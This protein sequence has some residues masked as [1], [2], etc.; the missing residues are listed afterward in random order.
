M[1][2]KTFDVEGMTCASC[3]RAVEKSVKK[4]KGVKDVSVNLLANK[5]EVTFDDSSSN[6]SEIK[7]SVAKAGYKA[8]ESGKDNS[9]RSEETKV[10]KIKFLVSLVFVVPLLYIAMGHMFGLPLPTFINPHDNLFNFAL[11]QLLLS[12]PVIVIGYK[13]YTVGFKSLFLLSPNMDSLVAL[14]TSTAFGYGVYTTMQI[15][16]GNIHEANLYFESAAVIITMIMLGKYFE[17][18]SKGRT[19]DAIRKL[20]DMS[21]KMATLLVDGQEQVVTVE[22]V[23]VGDYLIVKPGERLPVD[24]VI[25]Q[26][27]TSVDES[28][29]TG[30]PLP[31]D[32]QVGEKV[33]GASING[34]GSIIYQAT[35]V[36]NDTVLAQI[37]RLVESAQNSK[38]PIAKLA[39]KISGIFV[40]IVLGLAIVALGFW[41]LM[42]E[43]IEF[44][45]STMIAVLVIACP[46]AL[47]LA[48]PTAI[49]VGTG[50]GAEHG[51][52]I[53]SGEAFQKVQ[54]T[55][56]VV[57][58]KTGTI[59]SGKPE[60][61]D[62][63]AFEGDG[64]TLLSLVA[65]VEARS[66]HPLAK[67]IV[68]KAK[69]SGFALSAVD[70]FVSL[71][72][73]GVV[74][75]A[76]GHE[77][78]IGNRAM[79]IDQ[80]I[81]ISDYSSVI[82]KLAEEGKT[83][84]Y[85]AIDAR[86]A[87]IIAVSDTIKS[88]AKS[89]ISALHKQNIKV[90]M[91]TGDNQRTANEVARKTGIDQVI[92]DVLPQ[93]KAIEIRKLRDNGQVVV[94]VGDGIN[95]AIALA[96]ADVGIAIGSGT[97]IAIESASIVLMRGD[98]RD[99]LTAIDLSKKTMKNV[100]ENLFWAFF[101]N[102]LGI[103]VAMGLL[104]LFGGPLLDPMIAGA[105]MSFSSVS[106]VLNAL[107]LKRFKPRK[108]IL[109]HD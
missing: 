42:G 12:V 5:M 109:T 77:V 70:N 53:K 45:I 76:N 55:T 20:I 7:K 81:V 44:A 94:M 39:D 62:M 49:M 47:G 17:A 69:S 74:G 102:L 11:V 100:K 89:V 25:T 68:D 21:P 32:K 56:I 93:D 43:N 18:L 67:A 64:D 14:G 50:K 23:M 4:V 41:L 60:V 6:I 16:L 35:K 19:S 26:G 8:K 61:S 59:T 52:L 1:D 29:L 90:Y 91:L 36:G 2:K 63:I 79:M 104:H 97:D 48:T 66:E 58:D 24:G 57:F 95:D 86:L 9:I 75:L 99:V 85:V 103:P 87:G 98:L 71:P 82:E 80:G 22:Q 31:V 15:G 84:M 101:Y 92:A 13:F 65:S 107:R 73:R 30:E 106:V 33:I 96:E 10:L 83:A 72:G 78:K 108:D 54:R 46:C 40:P 27:L 38:A 28:M 3:V 34:N 105:A 51:I 88:E 37:I